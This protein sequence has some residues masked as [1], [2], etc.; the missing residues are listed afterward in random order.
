MSEPLT[1]SEILFFQ[2]VCAVCGYYAGSL[3]G[4]WTT[5]LDEAE[6]RV[7]QQRIDLANQIGQVETSRP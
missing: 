2:R 3:D 6:R 5:D 1:K 4:K 7:E